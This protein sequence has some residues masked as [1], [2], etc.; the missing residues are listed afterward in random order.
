MPVASSSQ[1][2]YPLLDTSIRVDPNDYASQNLAMTKGE[3]VQVNM[4][5]DNQTIFTFDIMDQKQ[6]YAFYA[7]APLCKQPLLGGN[8]TFDQQAGEASATYVNSTVTPSTPYQGSFTAPADGT[9]YFVFDN[10]VG[11]SWNTYVNQNA[12]PAFTTGHFTMAA[13]QNV[14]AFAVNWTLVGVGIAL[15]LVGG[16]VATATWES[17]PKAKPI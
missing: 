16:I 13:A 8:G 3:T 1:Q 2:M 12:G 5:I 6:Y 14:T 17:K 10:S 4:Q 7:C 11:P 9:Y 15:M